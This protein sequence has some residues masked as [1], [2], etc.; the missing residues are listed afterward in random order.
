MAV[1][2]HTHACA[3]NVL[4]KR[5]SQINFIKRFE[6]DVADDRLRPTRQRLP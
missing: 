3:G 6:D 2:A 5:C 1:F 4:A